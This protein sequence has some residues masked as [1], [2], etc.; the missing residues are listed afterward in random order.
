MGDDEPDKFPSW[1]RR[2]PNI[3]G[4]I[5]IV[6]LFSL[7]LYSEE[8]DFAIMSLLFFGGALAVKNRQP[9]PDKPVDIEGR[10]TGIGILINVL[11]FSVTYKPAEAG[12]YGVESG[13][14]P[15]LRIYPV[16]AALGWVLACYGFRGLRRYWQIP[17]MYLF[18]GMPWL[19]L[20]IFIDMA[21]TTAL[22]VALILDAIG[23]NSYLREPVFVGVPGGEVNVNI[24]CSGME[25]MTYLLGLS[26]LALIVFKPPSWL[27]YF[28]VPPIAITMAFLINA[29][30]V[31]SLAL[32]N[33]NQ[34]PDLFDSFHV[35]LGSQLFSGST[36]G[37][38]CLGYY[39]VHWWVHRKT[40]TT[41]VR[42]VGQKSGS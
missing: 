25:A 35:G 1:A 38:F 16:L 37:L 30:R 31:T 12:M 42:T 29:I 26:V 13:A 18:L 9:L 3:L 34:R 11:A 15:W 40:W 33:A 8:L 23:F 2:L 14:N 39:A 32:L 17:F 20:R 36:V 21:M 10:V 19:V 22:V 41:Q 4:V 5:L 28:L 6:I 24:G 27:W 7:A